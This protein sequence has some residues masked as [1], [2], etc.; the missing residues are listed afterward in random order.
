MTFKP[1]GKLLIMCIFCLL[2]LI[3]GMVTFG[4]RGLLKVCEVRTEMDNILQLN[5]KLAKENEDLIR[6]IQKLKCDKY[7]EEIARRDLGLIKDGELIYQFEQDVKK[8]LGEIG[9]DG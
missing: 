8:P 4:H 3:G 7:V 2:L 5:A 6:E 1:S 9:T